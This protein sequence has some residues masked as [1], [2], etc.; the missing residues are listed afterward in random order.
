[1][2]LAFF[3]PPPR[4]IQ[5]KTPRKSRNMNTR[6]SVSMLCT[7]ELQILAGGID[8]TR[9]SRLQ[10]R[11][12]THRS[13]RLKCSLR[14]LTILTTLPSCHTQR[15]SSRGEHKVRDDIC[16][17]VGANLCPYPGD[18]TARL[19]PLRVVLPV[20]MPARIHR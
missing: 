9:F 13:N 19:E 2:A 6:A 12:R 11:G 1:M 8:E 5:R 4:R 18:A 14:F 15:Y 3:F 17:E 16:R 7:W 20:K 10:E